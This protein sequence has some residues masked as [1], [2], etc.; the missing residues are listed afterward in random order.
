LNRFKAAVYEGA[1]PESEFRVWWKAE[2][3][4]VRERAK[5]TRRRNGTGNA[6]PNWSARPGRAMNQLQRSDK[7]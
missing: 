3:G 5:E 4:R 1:D 6:R 7:S 2:E